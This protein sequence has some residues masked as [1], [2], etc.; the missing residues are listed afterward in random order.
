MKLKDKTILTKRKNFLLAIG[1]DKYANSRFNLLHNAAHD[2]KLISGILSEKYDFELIE[3]PIINEKATRSKI[4]DSLSQLAAMLTKEDNLIIYFAGHGERNTLTNH[5]YWVPFDGNESQSSYIPNSTI[6]DAIEGIEAKHVF[7]ISDSCYSGTFLT[8]TRSIQDTMFYEKLDALKSRWVFASGG[9]EKVSDGFE[10]GKGSP[11]CNELFSYLNKNEN[12]HVAV[13]EIINS[14]SLTTRQVAKQQPIGAIMQNV[15]HEDG[16]MILVLNEKY[17]KHENDSFKVK[18]KEVYREDSFQYSVGKEVL[19]VK[20]FV[21]KADYLIIELFRFDDEGNQRH[22][23]VG[24]TVRLVKTK[25]K[26]NVE[27]DLIQ[28]F[29]TGSGLMR[30]LDEHPELSKKNKVVVIPAKDID[31]VESTDAAKKHLKKLQ[32]LKVSNTTLMLCL[33]CRKNIDS[34][35]SF[36]V[37]IDEQDLKDAV[38]NVHKECLRPADRI[39]GKSIYPDLQ[40]ASSL[41]NFDINEWAHLLQRGQGLISG[42]QGKDFGNKIPII[43]WNPDHG[44][45]T[46]KFCIRLIAKD[47]S[48]TYVHL[49]KAV[50]RFKEAEIDDE[51]NFFKTKLKE[52]REAG[53]PACITSVKKVFG[54]L[55]YL[56]TIKGEDEE[57]LEIVDAEKAIYSHQLVQNKTDIDNDYAPL[58]IV[59]DHGTD[60]IIN[61]GN[62]IPIISNPLEF[63]DLH[64][65]WKEA[66]FNIDKCELRIA[67]SDDEFDSYM[68]AFLED[69]MQPILNPMF[70]TKAKLIKGFRIVNVKELIERNEVLEKKRQKD[71]KE[72]FRK[73]QKVEVIFPG[74]KMPKEMVGVLAEDEFED[75][76]GEIC[77]IFRPIEDGKLTDLAFKMPVKLFRIID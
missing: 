4:I 68:K 52:R 23:F 38:G 5:G 39:L 3:E 30:Y 72:Q 47:K 36:F 12:K 29:A 19:L 17:Y 20:S 59:T 37:E 57:I 70:D 35:D 50:H 32:Q 13:T 69:G 22:I 26:E 46:G 10:P 16:Q 24:N 44:D 51:L 65:N 77:S 63:D 21:A 54:H 61:L 28:R 76:K 33:H 71:R 53:D 40:G 9:E 49:G 43:G 75:E 31:N 14:V 2:V 6:K 45:N 11:F 42:V 56:K 27:W 60:D 64:S 34:N 7:L 66:G 48:V 8:R 55:S 74:K 41:T 67:K 15:G 25:N 18:P 62:C 73:G 1:I 58:G